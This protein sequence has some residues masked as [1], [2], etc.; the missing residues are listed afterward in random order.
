MA[1]RRPGKQATLPVL[2]SLMEPPAVQIAN[3][4]VMKSSW[5]DPDD[6]NPH[7]R[8]AREVTGYRGFDPLRKCRK[9]HG[10]ASSITERHIAAADILRALC[11]GGRFGFSALKDYAMPVTE[12]RYQP[13]LGPPATA[14]RQAQCQ[15]RFVRAMTLFTFKESQLLTFVVLLNQSIA[16]WVDALAAAGV[17]ARPAVEMGKLVAILDQLEE[18]FSSEVDRE[19]GRA[20]T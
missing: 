4:Q 9:R 5:R 19:L 18:H 6:L 3:Q 13:L 15:T 8:L 2:P 20:A 17:A 11:D 1:K 10:D 16:K 7:Q 14:R 12:V